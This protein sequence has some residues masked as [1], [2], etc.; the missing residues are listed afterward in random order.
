MH[1]QYTQSTSYLIRNAR[2]WSPED[3]GVLDVL[4]VNQT[5]YAVEPNLGNLTLPNLKIIDAK[6]LNLVPGFIDG[7]VHLTGGGGEGGFSTRIQPAEPDDF[8]SHG[9]CTVVGLLGTDGVTRSL[10]DLY[11][12]VMAFRE[13][14]MSAWMYSGAYRVP[15]P[16]LTGS[17]Q[18]DLVLIQP[19]IGV[20]EVA[21][22]DHRSSQPT[23]Q[24]LAR[25]MADARVGGMISGKA[26]ITHVH[27]GDDPR[28]LELLH[29]VI[30]TTS[31]PPHHIYPTHVNRHRSL[32]KSA[33]ALAK[34]GVT[35]DMTSGFK[36][37]DTEVSAPTC[38]TELLSQGVPPRQITLSSDSYGSLPVFDA[39]GQL[40]G[41]DWAKPQSLV[42]DLAAM[43][44]QGHPFSL[45]LSLVTENPARLLGLAKVGRILPGATAHL[46]LCDVEFGVKKVWVSGNAD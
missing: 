36:D 37:H 45:V 38:L 7:H 30:D 16:T 3:L 5:I 31:I 8:K 23:A 20:G 4:I 22:G 39:H 13:A 33:T 43:V 1:N 9:I 12:R 2:V 11:A 32:V 44:K 27:L 35:L 25:T 18:Q 26:G 34:R 6:G 28:G 24:E 19:V 15:G 41:I 42:Q 29:R 21:V 46:V 14:G 17:V 40:V 10:V